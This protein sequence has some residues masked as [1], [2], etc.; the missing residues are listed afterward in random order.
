MQRLCEDEHI[1]R[2]YMQNACIEK[3]FCSPHLLGTFEQEY[4]YY[5]FQPHYHAV[6]SSS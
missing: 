5:L 4:L 6:A 3:I 1:L 2:A